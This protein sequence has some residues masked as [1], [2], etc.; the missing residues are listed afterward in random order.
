MRPVLDKQRQTSSVTQVGQARLGWARLGQATLGWARLGQARLC[1]YIYIYIYI[2]IYT[3]MYIH[4]HMYIHMCIH[5]HIHIHIHTYTYTQARLGVP[6]QRRSA[7]RHRRSCKRSHSLNVPCKTAPVAVANESSQNKQNEDIHKTPNNTE[8]QQKTAPV[9][10]NDIRLLA[11]SF[12]SPSA[13]KTKSGAARSRHHRQAT[14]Q[15]YCM[16]A[17]YGLCLG[18][19]VQEGQAHS[20]DWQQLAQTSGV[21]KP[22]GE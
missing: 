18:A 13:L 10:M 17:Q 2:Y 21:T 22:L 15:N 9:A 19:C 12:E 3:P 7:C 4:I 14:M 11:R 1:M 6:S 5:I 8:K 20:S 16:A